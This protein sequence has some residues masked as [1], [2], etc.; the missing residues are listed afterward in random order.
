VPDEGTPPWHPG[1]PTT[2]R[3]S[4][5]RL[6][7]VFTHVVDAWTLITTSTEW[8]ESVEDLVAQALDDKLHLAARRIGDR[9]LDARRR[10]LR[11]KTRCDLIGSDPQPEL[12][13]EEDRDSFTIEFSN[14]VAAAAQRLPEQ[15]DEDAADA[16][17]KAEQDKA[18]ENF[19]TV[20]PE[21]R[22]EAALLNRR[23]AGL[24]AQRREHPKTTRRRRA[25]FGAAFEAHLTGADGCA[26]DPKPPGT[27]LH[28][29]VLNRAK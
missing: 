9:Y 29:L 3:V 24:A 6:D 13:A 15:R 21:Y 27:Q 4:T 12:K 8:R 10:A 28:N 18:L 22:G 14:D 17:R 19:L 5:R 11:L 26:R 2:G 25:K 16:R 23:V 1:E 20:H 7:E